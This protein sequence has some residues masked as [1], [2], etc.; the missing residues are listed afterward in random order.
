MLNDFKKF[1]MRG[2]VVDMA[3]GIVIG[4]AFGSI[5]KSLVADVIM[6]PI[7]VLISGVDFSNM[8]YVVKQGATAVPEGASLEVARAT[9]AAIMS[10]GVFINFVINF[11]IV[12]FA[13]FM[14]VRV[15]SKMQKAQPP[16]DPTTKEC[17]E[18]LSKIPLKATRCSHCTVEVKAA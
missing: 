16:A 4:A 7:G 17:P 8:Y 10:F 18:C 12:G 3:V 9:G 5:I 13:V 15:L 14:V 6:P 1:I 11:L 2:N